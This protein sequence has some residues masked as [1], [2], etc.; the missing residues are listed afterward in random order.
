MECENGCVWLP[1][2]VYNY[3]FVYRRL[4]KER[5]LEALGYE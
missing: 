2:L 5:S 1:L 4:G 3:C